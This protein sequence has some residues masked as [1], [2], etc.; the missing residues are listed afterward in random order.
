MLKF[1]S[2]FTTTEQIQYT[3]KVEVHTNN[4]LTRTTRRAKNEERITITMIY[5]EMSVPEKNKEKFNRRK[6]NHFKI[7]V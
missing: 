2:T 6:I 3:P 5:V 1:V 7:E 4:N